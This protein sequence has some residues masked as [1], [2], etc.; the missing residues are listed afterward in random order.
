MQ[1]SQNNLLKGKGECD[2]CGGRGIV[3][4]IASFRRRVPMMVPCQICGGSG[5]DIVK[6][7]P[8][9]ILRVTSPMN[10]G[11]KRLISTYFSDSV[12]PKPAA[13]SLRPSVADLANAQCGTQGFNK[14]G[15]TKV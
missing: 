9:P 14:I 6:P 7:T 8:I 1:S 4:S 12:K 11:A 13:I 3:R 10:P 5:H 15:E 2:S